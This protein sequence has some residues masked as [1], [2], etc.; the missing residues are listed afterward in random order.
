MLE[1]DVHRLGF[2]V[3]PNIDN[4]VTKHND[5]SRQLTELQSE[6]EFMPSSNLGQLLYDSTDKLADSL[7]VA[8]LHLENIQ[9]GL[10]HP[11]TADGQVSHLVE[12]V[13]SSATTLKFS[14]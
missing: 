1:R 13:R 8:G 3:K 2:Y 7:I 9:N 5:I 11:S 10:H 4:A 6:L 12:K 14:H